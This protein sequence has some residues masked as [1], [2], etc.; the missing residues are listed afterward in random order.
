MDMNEIKKLNLIVN[1]LSTID[2]E[3]IF[4]SVS[5]KK[6]STSKIAN[7]TDAIEIETF[8][9]FTSA[10]IILDLIN[11]KDVKVADLTFTSL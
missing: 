2:K 10:Q 11:K 7:C 4:F 9:L 5:L 6:I 1:K 8:P 3:L